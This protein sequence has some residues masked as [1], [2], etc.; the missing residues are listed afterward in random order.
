M[1]VLQAGRAKTGEIVKDLDLAPERPRLAENSSR[2]DHAI[3]GGRHFKRFGFPV[4]G[5]LQGLGLAHLPAVF[6]Q[7][8]S[9]IV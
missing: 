8:T 3:L 4:A 7:S 1:R 6:R 9:S 2:D 5:L